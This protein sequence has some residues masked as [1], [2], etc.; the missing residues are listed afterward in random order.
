MGTQSVEGREAKLAAVHVKLTKAVGALVTG[1]GWKRALEFAAKFRSRTK[2]HDLDGMPTQN[3]C[4][5][6][7]PSTPLMCARATCVPLRTST[8]DH[9]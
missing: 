3:R 7:T 1:E 6:G 2:W 9:R 8:A 5:R 4:R